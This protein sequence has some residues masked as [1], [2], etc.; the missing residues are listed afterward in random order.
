M[1]SRLRC[2][3]ESFT[4]CYFERGGRLGGNA[5]HGQSL[6]LAL[7]LAASKSYTGY[8]RGLLELPACLST[9]LFR[10]IAISSVSDFI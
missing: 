8:Q 5:A 6:G 9:Q 3:N 2:D 1:R 10:R 4:I 7:V